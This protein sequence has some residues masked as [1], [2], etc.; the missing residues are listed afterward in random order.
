MSVCRFLIVVAVAAAAAGLV[1]LLPTSSGL[2][3]VAGSLA[4]LAALM[5][6]PNQRKDGNG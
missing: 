3:I 1:S 4:A 5:Y 6:Q 2:G